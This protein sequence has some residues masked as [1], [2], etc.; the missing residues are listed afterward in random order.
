MS[1]WWL[2]GIALGAAWLFVFAVV[3][4][5]CK[6]AAE[7]DELSEKM[8]EELTHPAGN[9]HVIYRRSDRKGG[10]EWAD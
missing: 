3:L 4:G 1:I 6:V 7:G 8:V 9:V 5:L 10:F 2:V